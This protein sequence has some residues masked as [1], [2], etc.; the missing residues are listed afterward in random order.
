MEEVVRYLHPYAIS[1]YEP[2]TSTIR[3]LILLALCYIYF[4][5]FIQALREEVIHV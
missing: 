3:V 2:A 5:Y 4:G 1:M